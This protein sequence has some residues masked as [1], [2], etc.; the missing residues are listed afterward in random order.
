VTFPIIAPE[1]GDDTD[2]EWA[3]D[4]TD[5]V[6]DHEDRVA[7]VERFAVESR[8][9]SYWTGG[10]LASSS[11]AETAHAAWTADKSF[12]FFDGRIYALH[13]QCLIYN[14]AAGFGTIERLQMNIRK[15]V[16]STSAQLLGA[17][18]HTTQGTGSSG[19]RHVEWTAYIANSTGA[20]LTGVHLGLTIN[21]VTGAAAQTM[22][23]D[24]S[25]PAL[26]RA[27]DLGAVAD[28]PNLAGL[29]V[30]IT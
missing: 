8:D 10:A 11:G 28:N 24:A 20:D 9:C 30:E 26:I 4:I 6:N 12:T 2:P 17:S 15:A 3:G 25:F 5:A 19:A 18:L 7:V 21:R 16:N 1:F 29:A 27:Q 23:G 13:V 22:Y 14:A